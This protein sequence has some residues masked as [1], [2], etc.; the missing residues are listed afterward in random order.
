MYKLALLAIVTI[1][2][3]DTGATTND[4]CLGL[5]CRGGSIV[6]PP[7]RATRNDRTEASVVATRDSCEPGLVKGLVCAPGKQVFVSDASIVIEGTGC[8][9]RKFRVETS[10]GA[11]GE[12]VLRD[13]PPGEHTVT[14]TK[15][16][17]VRSTVVKVTSGQVADI[18]GADAKMCFTPHQARIAVLE[19]EW[20]DLASFVGDLG[21]DYDL[22][23]VTPDDA[24]DG[25]I[26]DLLADPTRL[27]SYDI[28][29][30]GCGYSVGQ[31]AIE[32]PEQLVH[33]HDYVLQ[34]GSLYLSDYAWTLGES[35]FPAAIDFV[36][37]D[38]PKLMGDCNKSPQQI[39][40]DE[41][42]SATITDPKLASWLG[43]GTLQVAFDDGPQIAAEAAGAGTVVH[44]AADLRL[45]NGKTVKQAPL[46]MSYQPAPG[47][48]RVVYTNFH[49]DAQSTD[50]I[51]KI[52]RF[53]V[54]TL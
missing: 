10:S 22:F 19:G 37:G 44:V 40:S 29:F 8:A 31:I 24:S 50:D 12:Y 13:V 52:M 25:T 32:H 26:A 3:C 38:D 45:M 23:T 51:L 28:V 30:V 49:N 7:A 47:A 42:V 17:F 33:I 5:E 46:A 2:A 6:V 15:G 34:G 48:G 53:L 1:A 4:E 27:F 41:S 35:A 14:I 18:S 9:G 11:D 39:P 43:K 21:F 20:D 16:S 36:Q 54:F